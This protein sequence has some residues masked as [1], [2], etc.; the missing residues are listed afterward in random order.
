MDRTT[1]MGLWRY[2]KDFAVAGRATWEANG[3]RAN[4]PGYYLLGHSIELVLKAYLRG[5]G[6]SI[7]ALQNIG[8]DL[9]LAIREAEKESLSSYV[10]LEKKH[11]AA[12]RILNPHYSKKKLEYI[13][14]GFKRYPDFENL[15]ST[16]EHLLEA[17]HGFCRGFADRHNS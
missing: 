5:R 14:S 16:T 10:T 9:E 3:R 15:L 8:H 7:K 13:E 1:S 17:L 12:I 6:K 2:G 11:Q 4:A